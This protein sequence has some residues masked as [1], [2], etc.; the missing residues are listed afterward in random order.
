MKKINE[1]ITNEILI[2]E[3]FFTSIIGFNPSKGARSPL[4]WNAA[5][6]EFDFSAKMY[7]LDVEKENLENLIQTLQETENYKGGAVAAPYKIIIADILK[8]NLT[9]E[10]KAIGAINCIF[11]DRNGF[12]KG[13]NTDG[14]AALKCILKN[15]NAFKN[16]DV[17][18][19]GFGGVSK[20]V[21]AYVSKSLANQAKLIVGCRKENISQKEMTILGI[22]KIINIQNTKDYLEGIKVL[23]NCTSVGWNEQSE[24]SPISKDE[25]SL[26]AKDA[27]IFDVIYQPLETKFLSFANELGIKNSNGLEMNLEQALLAFKYALPELITNNKDNI[28][29]LNA[30]KNA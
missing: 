24:F 3:K 23:I 15:I 22:S 8:N 1:L 18:V 29:L 12:L 16:Y 27:F 28:R 19:L 10:A 14:E 26:L 21:C 2:N 9:P 7:P 11:R 6:K 25:L 4:L 30:M 13:T 17:L 5:F 20:A